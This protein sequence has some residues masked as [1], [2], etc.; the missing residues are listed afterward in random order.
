MKVNRFS[1]AR[2]DSWN[3]TVPSRMTAL[4]VNLTQPRIAREERLNEGLFT[5]GW[6]V[7]MSVEDRLISLTT[8]E[9]PAHRGLHHSL[10]RE[11][12]TV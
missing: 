1:E 6:P 9:D 7:A 4:T 8:W 5:L 3:T 2:R 12:W 11:S 10:A